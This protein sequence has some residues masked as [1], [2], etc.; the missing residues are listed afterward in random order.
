M[1]P[2]SLIGA[3][4]SALVAAVGPWTGDALANGTVRPLAAGPVFA[5]DG[6]AW[7]T[8]D[9]DLV[10]PRH[11]YGFVVRRSGP[12]GDAGRVLGRSRSGPRIVEQRT[13]YLLAS[14]ELVVAGAVAFELGSKAFNGGGRP[15]AVLSWAPSGAA[16]ARFGSCEH[17]AGAPVLRPGVVDLDGHEVVD[18]DPDGQHI[19]VFD[20]RSGQLIDQAPA[21]RPV[22]ARIAGPYVAWLE[23]PISGDFAGGRYTLVVYDRRTRA[24]TLRLATTTLGPGMLGAWDLDADGTIAYAIQPTP[25]GDYSDPMRLGWTS[26]ADPT[27]HPIGSGTLRQPTI[28]LAA[29]RIVYSTLR[30]RA[31]DIATLGLDGSGARTLARGTTRDFDLDATRLAVGVPGCD[32][33]E[34][35]VQ[36]LSAPTFTAPSRHC[37]LA[38]SATTLKHR[39]TRL[40]VTLR[41]RG[42]P[43]TCD[44]SMTLR[45]RGTTAI[46]GRG[47]VV[48]GKGSIV[49]R[50]AAVRALAHEHHVAGRLTATFSLP[51]DTSLSVARSRDVQVA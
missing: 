11:P 12:G 26:P 40:P 28:R 47:T 9:R 36:A 42:L 3:L 5:G 31:F 23:S 32:Q 13:P 17:G 51:L 46:L 27:P 30:G 15:A 24:E 16:H 1:R 18:C 7:A 45:R 22:S 4:V 44:G 35:H 6:V 39:A 25:S 33:D 48:D 43:L 2:R 21:A 20:G 10:S 34:I 41:C 37:S 14:S 49:L 50:S 38:L 29:H 8:Y 19:D